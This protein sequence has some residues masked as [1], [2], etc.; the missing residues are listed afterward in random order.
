VLYILHGSVAT[1]LRCGK[2]FSKHVIA[3]CP[4]SVPV[5]ELSLVEFLWLTVYMNVTISLL[6]LTWS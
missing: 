6:C 3:N 2:V 1:Q 4:Q 5:K